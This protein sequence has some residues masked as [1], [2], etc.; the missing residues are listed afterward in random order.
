ME[1][2]IAGIVLL[3]ISWFASPISADNIATVQE[4]APPV[5]VEEVAPVT[6]EDYMLSPSVLVRKEGGGTGS[7]VAFATDDFSGTR[8][9]TNHHIIA[10]EIG[11]ITVQF[12][13]EPEI[14]YIA[15]IV[16]YDKELDVAVLII[17]ETVPHVAILGT[18][19]DV[20]VFDEVYCV[21]SPM[22]LPTM[23][24][25][26]IVS[27]VDLFHPNMKQ[28]YFQSDCKI[29]SGNSGGGMFVQRGEQWVLIGINTW[30]LTGRVPGNPMGG[31]FP[32]AHL[33]FAVRI[34][35][36]RGHLQKYGMNPE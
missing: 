34:D 35:D 29:F 25:K 17:E 12:Y 30:V 9:L 16:S 2:R 20:Q 7:G 8:I 14:A 11:G 3:I 10:G 28:H 15:Y 4:H 19:E 36:I 26:G 33:G 31:R 21:G 27:N 23:A 18:M 24:T 32:I 13:D 1:I 6:K 22:G 5:S